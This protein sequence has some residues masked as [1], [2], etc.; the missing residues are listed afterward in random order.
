[1]EVIIIEGLQ[2]LTLLPPGLLCVFRLS[3]LI[4]HALHQ[5]PDAQ[6]YL[7]DY[8]AKPQVLQVVHFEVYVDVFCVEELGLDLHL[9]VEEVLVVDCNEGQLVVFEGRL[10]VLV[11]GQVVDEVEAL[12][13]VE[14]EFDFLGKAVHFHLFFEGLFQKLEIEL[15]GEQVSL[16]YA[17]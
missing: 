9:S 3:L 6:Y 17:T 13:F 4:P 1:M 15:E 7:F 2:L 5:E 8:G 12:E 10:K 14:G 11:P 16:Q